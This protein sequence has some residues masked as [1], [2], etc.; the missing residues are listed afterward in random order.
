[1][2]TTLQFNGFVLLLATCKQGARMNVIEIQPKES[3]YNN[4]K[5]VKHQEFISL[6][7]SLEYS[8]TPMVFIKATDNNGKPMIHGY[9][10][11]IGHESLECEEND[12]DG[13]IYLVSARNRLRLFKTIDSISNYLIENGIYTFKITNIL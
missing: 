11:S 7:K 4:E 2:V 10:L 12:Y 8:V 3:I 13:C 9:A 5:G 6:C 1:M